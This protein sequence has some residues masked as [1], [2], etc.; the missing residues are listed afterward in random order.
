MKT[1]AS[2]VPKPAV[3]QKILAFS[4]VANPL[5]NLFKTNVIHEGRRYS[6]SEQ[7]I[8]FAKADLYG[9]QASAMKILS[10]HNPMQCL[11]LGKQVVGFR[12]NPSILVQSG[13]EY[14]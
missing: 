3:G 9:D 10:C 14:Y 2:Q 13:Q 12:Q 7:A 11:Q 4:G 6:S 8:Q 1:S 5:S